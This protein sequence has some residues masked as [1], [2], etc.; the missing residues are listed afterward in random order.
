MSFF[1]KRL[2]KVMKLTNIYKSTLP[3]DII[4]GV[5]SLINILKI[6][7]YIIPDYRKPFLEVCYEYT[8]FLVENT[9]N[10]MILSVFGSNVE[11]EAANVPTWVADFRNI[12][13][14][15]KEFLALSSV[16]FSADGRYMIIEGI[17]LRPCV[18]VLEPASD[19]I[20]SAAIFE[21]FD[22]RILQPAYEIRKLSYES[23]LDSW[24]ET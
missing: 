16:T 12:Y 19:E 22:N 2:F 13:S 21:E 7:P 11:K 17:E 4:Y 23:V 10:L 8:K 3:H 24:L 15:I 1:V 14:S 6:P 18:S 20:I 9:E 5:L